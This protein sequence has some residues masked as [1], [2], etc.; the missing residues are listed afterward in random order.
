MTKAQ[1]KAFGQR[2]E[3]RKQLHAALNS[4]DEV[5]DGIFAFDSRRDSVTQGPALNEMAPG[6]FDEVTARLRALGVVLALNDLA[7]GDI[8]TA[9]LQ[10]FAVGFPAND[11]LMPELQFLAPDVQCGSRVTEYLDHSGGFG[12]ESELYDERGVKAEFK[13]IDQK[14]TRTAISLP[15]RGLASEVDEEQYRDGFQQELQNRVA[16][17]IARLHLN[18][19]RRAAAALLAIDSNSSKTWST[20]AGKDPDGDIMAEISTG[21]A[22]TGVRANKVFF[23]ET[24]W[25]YRGTSCRAQNTAGG[26]ASAMLTPEQLAPQLR[27]QGVRVSNA[28]YTDGGSSIASVIA[29]LVFMFNSFNN[30][31][32]DDSSILKT[33][34]APAMGQRYRVLPVRQVGDKMWRVAVECNDK[35]VVTGPATNTVRSFTTANA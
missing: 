20:A 11:D 26:F 8:L 19:L 33:L 29:N 17:I 18:R 23:G 10:S 7:T 15:N 21:H 31:S 32:L 3:R 34:W 22:A 24:A 2:M 13:T 27:V 12:V 4:P 9:P 16:R 35:T 5:P 28:V 30:V 25:S 14:G 6:R 1:M